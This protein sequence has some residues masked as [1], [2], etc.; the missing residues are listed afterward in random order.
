MI[1]I[2]LGLHGAVWPQEMVVH[3]FLNGPRGTFEIGK[4]DSEPVTESRARFYGITCVTLGVGLFPG[5][6]SST[7]KDAT[8]DLVLEPRDEAATEPTVP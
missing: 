3:H 4:D 5:A 7:A 8:P 6:L 1:L 2:L